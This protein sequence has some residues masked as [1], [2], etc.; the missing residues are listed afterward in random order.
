MEG[1]Y[2]VQPVITEHELR[3]Y[4]HGKQAPVPAE[5]RMR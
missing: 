1:V 3:Q 4:I 5:Y 2:P